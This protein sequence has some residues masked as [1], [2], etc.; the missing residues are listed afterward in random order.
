MKPI[1]VV[2]DTSVIVPWIKDREETYSKECLKLFHDFVAEEVRV[3]VPQL[4]FHEISNFVVIGS[5]KEAF[6]EDNLRKLLSMDFSVYE[7]KTTD[8]LDISRMAHE[9]KI[10]AYD[11]TYMHIAEA[12]RI[13]LFTAD[14]QLAKAWG[15]R[16]G[17]H[18]RRYGLS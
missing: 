2:A 3:I 5:R 13:P 14:E 10:T 12:L 9:K 4:F 16:P 17:G 1:E 8:F 15:S 7:L 6:P 18:I 11:A